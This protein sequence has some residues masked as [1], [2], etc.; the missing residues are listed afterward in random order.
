MRN[1]DWEDIEV[2]VRKSNEYINLLKEFLP[3]PVPDPS[4][5]QHSGPSQLGKML[6]ALIDEDYF[7]PPTQN[8]GNAVSVKAML[9]KAENTIM[10]KLRSNTIT[11]EPNLFV[12]LPSLI[13]SSFSDFFSSF[14]Y[15]FII[16]TINQILLIVITLILLILILYFIFLLLFIIKFTYFMIIMVM[17]MTLSLLS[18]LFKNDDELS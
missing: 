9:N 7:I 3:K 1:V 14:S 4:L 18:L 6:T 10:R 13:S 2:E 17:V 15:Y 8:N 16:M 5:H 12:L 11:S